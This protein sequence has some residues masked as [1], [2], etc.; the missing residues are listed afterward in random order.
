M[1]IERTQVGPALGLRVEATWPENVDWQ[2]RDAPG[3][4]SNPVSYHGGVKSAQGVIALAARLVGMQEVMGVPIDFTFSTH[5]DAELPRLLP[6]VMECLIDGHAPMGLLESAR[7]RLARSARELGVVQIPHALEEALWRELRRQL[8]RGEP[9][10]DPNEVD[11]AI[12]VLEDYARKGDA[13]DLLASVN[14]RIEAAVGK[15]TLRGPQDED[16]GPPAA[17]FDAD[18]VERLLDDI[19]RRFS[20]DIGS[21][22]SPRTLLEK[23]EDTEPVRRR[24]EDGAIRR[25][26]MVVLTTWTFETKAGRYEVQARPWSDELPLGHLG[27]LVPG[28]AMRGG[29]L[30]M[31]TWVEILAD[32]VAF[33]L[34]SGPGLPPAD[35]E[36]A[37]SG[38]VRHSV[39][40]GVGE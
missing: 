13:A 9:E 39:S 2:V 26:A 1:S 11:T 28:R 27:V 36:P 35:D 40:Y 22:D 12:R 32:I 20:T 10:S 21:P 6:V 38:A 24:G 31:S 5:G 18:D 25:V 8:E 17:P 19:V 29:S 16:A 7:N 3:Q 34:G 30:S 33:E 4:D 14:H 37:E 15:E 23:H